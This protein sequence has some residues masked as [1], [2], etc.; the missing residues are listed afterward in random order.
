M[1]T[2]CYS[3]VLLLLI[4]IAQWGISCSKKDNSGQ[5][6]YLQFT[7]PPGWPAPVYDFTA[8]PL[9]KEGVALGKKLFFDGRLSKDGNFPCVS[10]H[11]PFAAFATFDHDFSHGFNNQFTKRNAPGIFNLAWHSSFHMDGGITHLDLQPLAPITAPNEMAETLQGVLDKLNADP[12]YQQEFARVFGT[13]DINTA[14]MTKAL[15]QYMLMLVSA[16]SKYDLVKQG[17]ASFDVNQEA[18]YAVF[19]EKKCNR[20]H[21]EPLFTNLAFESNGLPLNPTLNDLGRMSITGNK[22]DSLKFKVPSLRNIALTFPYMHDGRFWSLQD[23]YDHYQQ[24]IPLSPVE[25]SLLTEF[26]KTL[27]DE[28][29]LTDP[30]LTQ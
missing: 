12:S 24:T 23:V 11:Q 17:K 2:L 29:L 20:C 18:G 4:A 10:C 7:A 26:L 19:L 13:P 22:A 25:R 15:S 6:S 1:K 27:T 14:N 16:N 21:T 28:K 5:L 8:N 30:S 9:S 3:T